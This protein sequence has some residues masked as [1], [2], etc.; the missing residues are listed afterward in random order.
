MLRT[1]LLS[2]VFAVATVAGASAQDVTTIRFGFSSVADL[3]NDN[4]ATAQLFKDYVERNSDT[5][6]VDIAGSSEIGNDADVIQA[7]Q[8]GSGATMHIGGTATYNTFLPRVGVL[9]LPFLWES[10]D[11]AGR[12]L[13]GEIG[14]E[15]A[16][17]F[18]AANLK[19]LGWGYSWG[20]RSVVTNGIEVTVPG[21]IE[22]LK[23]RTIQSPIYV[24]ALNA[25]GANATPM[26]FSEIYTAL[27]TGVLD[28]FEHAP[29]MVLS[30]NLHEVT[31]HIA[32]TRHLFGP[33]ALTYSLPLWNQLSEEEQ[34]V[35]QDGADWAIEVSRALAPGREEQALAQ[36]QE[37]GMTV[38]EID[39]SQ[40]KEAAIPLQE[41][42]AAD[43]GA[44]GLL[45]D[46][47]D[48]ADDSNE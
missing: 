20:F 9:D 41:E 43:I 33:T 24:A 47:R 25:M 39:T 22:G 7:L 13:D 19:V 11:H 31:D 34:Q 30:A 2:S 14:E 17:E 26:A 4:G 1:T 28:G 29:S 38:S 16:Q 10:Y 27:Q 23:L 46:I 12:A 3:Q 8:L 6:E 18:E 15:L 42:L 37:E 40:F 21:D 32:L 36:L 44:S 5:L 48:A 35:V 45:E